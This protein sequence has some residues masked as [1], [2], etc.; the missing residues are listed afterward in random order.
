MFDE[1]WIRRVDLMTAWFSSM[2]CG[3]SMQDAGRPG[4]SEIKR[5]SVGEERLNEQ[6]RGRRDERG[7]TGIE[8]LVAA[9]C[10]PTVP[11]Q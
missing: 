9:G 7:S 6:R 10:M 4:I 2:N 1:Q 8:A 5:R 11:Y 3:H